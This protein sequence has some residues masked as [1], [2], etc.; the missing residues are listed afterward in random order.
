[1]ITKPRPS[2]RVSLINAA[3]FSYLFRRKDS[4]LYQL[5]ISQISHPVKPKNLD[6]SAIPEEYYEFAKVLSKEEADKLPE[7]RP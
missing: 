6:L 3:A 1:L 7:Y 5:D 4:Q 2:P